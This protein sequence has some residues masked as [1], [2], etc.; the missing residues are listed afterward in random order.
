MNA[1]LARTLKNLVWP[2]RLTVTAPSE[3]CAQNLE[4]L[5]AARSAALTEEEYAELRAEMLDEIVSFPKMYGRV[6]GVLALACFACVAFILYGLATHKYDFVWDP[7][8]P[9]LVAALIWWC[10]GRA[11]AA[12]RALSRTDRLSIVD[13]LAKRNLISSDEFATMRAKIERLFANEQVA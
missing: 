9:L 5:R 8:L 13:E 6:R 2:P 1:S 3:A 4:E 11:Y 10:Q 12:K 7:I